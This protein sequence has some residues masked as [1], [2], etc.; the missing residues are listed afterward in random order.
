M[1]PIRKALAAKGVAKPTLSRCMVEE[2]EEGRRHRRRPPPRRAE[3][4]I[5]RMEGLRGRRMKVLSDRRAEGLSGRLLVR[6]MKLQ[7]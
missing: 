4:R 3:E 1:G 2:V 5:R 7:E 6:R